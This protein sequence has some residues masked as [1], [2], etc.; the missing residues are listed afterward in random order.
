MGVLSGSAGR[1][2]FPYPR[3][4]VEGLRPSLQ[5]MYRTPHPIVETPHARYYATSKSI[6]RLGYPSTSHIPHPTGH[7]RHPCPDVGPRLLHYNPESC[8][9]TPC[10][11]VCPHVLLYAPVSYFYPP[12]PAV[13]PRV[14]LYAPCPV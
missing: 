11:V 8:C 1:T 6:H 4:R 2:F 5:A 14:L 13:R 7:S 3:V 9:T 12:C 10:P